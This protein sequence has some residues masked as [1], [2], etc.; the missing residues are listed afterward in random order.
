MTRE[1]RDYLDLT[2]KSIECFSN[3]GKLLIDELKELMQLALKDG[4]VD[5][6]EKRVLNNIFNRLTPE[7]LTVEMIQE[8]DKIRSLHNF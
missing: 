6:D 4:V 5:D 8:I 7:E 1:N 3:D 2:F